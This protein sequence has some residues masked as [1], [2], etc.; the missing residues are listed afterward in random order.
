MRLKKEEKQII[1]EII[2]NDK[3]RLWVM[4]DENSSSYD[5]EYYNKVCSIF[6]KLK[7]QW[8][9]LNDKQE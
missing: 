6:K 4:I 7:D 1:L 3:E 5:K 2:E 8:G 9:D